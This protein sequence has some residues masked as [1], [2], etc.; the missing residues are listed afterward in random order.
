MEDL[1]T[2][3]GDRRPAEVEMFQRRQPREMT[4][5]LVCQCLG[6]A[7]VERSDGID[8]SDVRKHCVRHL[9]FGMKTRGWIRREQPDD[10]IPF[11]RA[12]EPLRFSWRFGIDQSYRLRR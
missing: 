3:I 4:H 8:A 9:A 1:K 11:A 5:T 2:A 10:R 6:A 12:G 7:E